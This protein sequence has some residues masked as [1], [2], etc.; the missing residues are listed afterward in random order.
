MKAFEKELPEGYTLAKHINATNA[1]F[2]IIFNLISI[3]V[4][5][6]ILL[7]AGWTI[8]LNKSMLLGFT[9][10]NRPLAMIIMAISIFAYIVLHEL[11]HG[12]AYKLTTKEELTFGLSWSCAFCGVPNIYTYRRT[13]L[14]ALL[15]PFLF[16]TAAMIPILIWLYFVHPYYYMCGALVFGLHVGGCSGDLYMTILL[17]TKFKDKTTLIR[18]TGPEQYIYQK[19]E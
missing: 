18:D 13:A 8:T 3:V 5:I 16:F 12:A 4:T 11:V 19:T 1:K 17:L 7:F 9:E 6:L 10:P 14:I 15:A 2:G